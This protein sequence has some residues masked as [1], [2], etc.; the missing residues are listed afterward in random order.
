MAESLKSLFNIMPQIGQVRWMG[1]RTQKRGAVQ[2]VEA[3]EVVLESGLLGDH[4]SGKSGKRQVTLIQ[5]EHIDTV[6]SI[7][8]KETV[9][10]A[11]LRRNIVV[12]GINLLALKDQQFQIGEAI[13]ETT[14]L[15]HPCSRMEANL[16]P[17]GYNAMRG[18]G[19]IT[20]RVIKGGTVKL[21]DPIQLIKVIEENKPAK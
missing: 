12:A 6:A 19:G 8:Q 10:P 17:G 21:G 5:Q 1:V 11:L 9:D 13:L 4:Y 14:G 3:V 20:A 7:L 2:Q 16:G 18:H 15:C